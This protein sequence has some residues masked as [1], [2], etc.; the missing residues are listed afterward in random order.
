MFV[1]ETAS[2][3]GIDRLRRYV[4]GSRQRFDSGIARNTTSGIVWEANRSVIIDHEAR[5]RI[6]I[7]W[8]N[9]IYTTCTMPQ[10]SGGSKTTQGRYHIGPHP[11]PVI[12][13]NRHAE[14]LGETRTLFDREAR[15]IRIREHRPPLPEAG[16]P[17]MEVIDEGWFMVFPELEAVQSEICSAKRP[18]CIGGPGEAMSHSGIEHWGFP[19]DVETR[20]R[21]GSNETVL[22]QSWRHYRLIELST[23]P[24]EPEIFIAPI[25]FRCVPSFPVRTRLDQLKDSG[26][27][28]R[29]F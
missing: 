29:F 6:E 16:L 1:E 5:K 19:A 8:P 13:V 14:E 9:R 23:C 10:T 12:P 22:P 15:R 24:L 17:E 3:T 11:A 18:S 28:R 20:T 2:S 21:E 25:D 27:L 26:L 4:S 7:D